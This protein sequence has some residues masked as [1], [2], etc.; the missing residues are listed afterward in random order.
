MKP[1]DGAGDRKDN[2]P[3]TTDHEDRKTSGV[4]EAQAEALKSNEAKAAEVGGK[5]T[6]I[7]QPNPGNNNPASQM[8]PESQ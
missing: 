2:K 5:V 8:G 1:A 4:K 7:D 3:Y 6:D